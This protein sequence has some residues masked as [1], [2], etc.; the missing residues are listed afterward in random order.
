MP[1]F[2]FAEVMPDTVAPSTAVDETFGSDDSFSQ[3]TA[4]V[5]ANNNQ[6]EVGPEIRRIVAQQEANTS[7]VAEVLHKVT[8]VQDAAV[9]CKFFKVL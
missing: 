2:I 1:L 3:T 5:N 7:A 4:N 8:L 9:T 6:N